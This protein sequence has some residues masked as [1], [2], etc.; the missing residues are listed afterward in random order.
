[1]FW[2]ISPI[3]IP[4]SHT[5]DSLTELMEKVNHTIQNIDS[6]KASV[7]RAELQRV[8]E[9]LEKPIAEPVSQITRGRPRGSK[10]T[11]RDPSVF[12]YALAFPGGVTPINKRKCKRCNIAGT[13]HN[14]ATCPLKNQ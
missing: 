2:H 6:S 3:E 13:G 1:M 5:Q 10:N 14:A 11:R 12:E 9:N 8:L 7:A 4:M